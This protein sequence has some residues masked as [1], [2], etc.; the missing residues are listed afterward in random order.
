M[1][2]SCALSREG[3]ELVPSTS[4]TFSSLSRNLQLWEGKR[5]EGEGRDYFCKTVLYPIFNS[6]GSAN[7]TVMSL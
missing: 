4:Q 3:T 6:S 7:E 1:C 2:N 5:R